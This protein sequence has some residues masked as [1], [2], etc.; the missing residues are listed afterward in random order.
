LAKCLAA[1]SPAPAAG[2]R[3]ASAAI[4]AARAQAASRPPA[5]PAAPVSSTRGPWL[6]MS[7]IDRFRRI[8]DSY[9]RGFGD[10]VLKAV[11]EAMHGLA[12]AGA[13]LARVG[14]VAF[15]LLVPELDAAEALAL[16]ERVRTHIGSARIRRPD[17][18]EA[19]RVTLSIGLASGRGGDSPEALV[20]R[21]EA[22]LSEARDAGED[23]IVNAG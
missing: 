10:K 4:E 18:Q 16:A 2:A 12:P 11:A 20:A 6:L 3:A 21:A 15:G 14:G 7:D 9:G 22:A 1:P 13:T 5:A 8:N 17:Q 23:R 19:Q